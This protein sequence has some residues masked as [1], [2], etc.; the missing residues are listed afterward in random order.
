MKSALLY[1]LLYC[2][3]LECYL[4]CL[5]S[6]FSFFMKNVTT[7]AQIVYDLHLVVHIFKFRPV[8]MF[9]SLDL[10]TISHIVCGHV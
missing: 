3:S 2:K 9:L 7:S 8:A 6:C 1:A 5:I 10:E 4:C